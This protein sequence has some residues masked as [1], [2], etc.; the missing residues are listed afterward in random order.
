MIDVKKLS[1]EDKLRLVMGENDWNNY[2]L[3]GKIYKFRVSDATC[4]LRMKAD[5][6]KSDD[7]QTP[8]TAYPSSQSIAN[9]WDPSLAY[10]MGRAMANDCIERGV[11]IVLGPGV[12]I[13]R[14]PVCGRNFEYYSEDPVLA[15]YIA[16]GYIEGLQS[17]HVGACIKHYCAN[18]VE[19]A[20]LFDS[21][22]VDERTLREIY[23]RVFE[24]AMEAK[25]WTVMCS[26]NLLNGKLMSENGKMFDLLRDEFG[27]DGLVM[28]DW[29]AVRRSS[30]SIN[31]G[32]D[33][34]MPYHESRAN[35]AR[36]DYKLGLFDEKMLDRAAGRVIKLAEKC[37]EES[38]KRKLTMTAEER[39]AFVV[40]AARESIV[41]LKNDNALPLKNETLMM[42]G[43]PE[44]SFYEGGGSAFVVP[45]KPYLRLGAALRELGFDTSYREAVRE[46]VGGQACMNGSAVSCRE[47]LETRDAA[48]IEVGDPSSV[49][50][51][52]RDRQTIKLCREEE[53]VIKYLRRTCPDK[54]I[55]VVIYAGS[56]IDMSDW[57]DDA[58]AVVWAGYCGQGGNRAVAE[59]L[60]GKVNPSGKLS[61]TFPLRLGD[62]RAMHSHIDPETV[63]YEEK[64]DVGYRY[65]TTHG[66]PVLFPFGFGLS[67]SEFEYSNLS[68][69]RDGG[70]LVAGFDIENVSDRDGCEIAQL[71]VSFETGEEGRPVRELK[72]FTKVRVPARSTVRAK[73]TVDGKLLSYFSEERKEFVPIG[74]MKVYVGKN[75]LDCALEAEVAG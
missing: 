67:Y 51:E 45:S 71:Y 73:I 14:L 68:V 74:G 19:Y 33:L 23:L 75:C 65:F 28:S 1:G 22:E 35:E 15:G 70:S 53:S 44:R 41:L 16:K 54:K 40:R 57:I 36:E 43:A 29:C 46:V 50:T 8:S 42:T 66:V 61:E 32:L 13:K 27:F 34:E 37:G 9:S 20:R 17:E 21:S 59:V 30:R 6:D 5:I 55:I 48:I 52:C 3:G 47:E 10:D 39:E 2:D 11:D 26:Y 56:A 49:E 24:I 25:P 60:A 63:V 4:G 31:G 58:D 62:V 7:P 18:N 12:N 72:G 64:L 69:E 38:K